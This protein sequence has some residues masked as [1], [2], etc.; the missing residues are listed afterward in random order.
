MPPISEGDVMTMPAK[1]QDQTPRIAPLPEAEWTQEMRDMF[2]GNRPAALGPSRTSNYRATLARHMDVF[3]KYSAYAGQLLMTGVLPARDKELAVLR[4]AWL[5]QG[6]FE[7]GSH[8]PIARVA[9]LT[10]GDIER[11]TRGPDAPGW[12]TE[13]AVV[14]RAVDELHLN[15]TISD[16]TWSLLAARYDERQLIEFPLVI[17]QYHTVAFVQNSLRIEL[18]EGNLGFGSLRRSES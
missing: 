16:A 9:G 17:G 3:R 4:T 11:V 12:K 15:G 10:D 14:L 7:W 1:R 5:C 8:V 18:D 13:D 6:E 2:S